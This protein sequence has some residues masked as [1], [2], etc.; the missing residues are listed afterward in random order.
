MYR[1]GKQNLLGIVAVLVTVTLSVSGLSILA[2][3][4]DERTPGA[5]AEAAPFQAPPAGAIRQEGTLI[6]PQSSIERLEDAGKFAHT[7][8]SIFV[9]AGRNM[10]TINP[11]NTFAEYPA[12]LAC[13]YKVGPA[14]PGC[15]PANNGKVATGGWGAIALVDAYDYPT[16]ASDLAFFSSYFGLPA[17][18]FF[19]VIA[20]SS[21]GAQGSLG[22]TASCSGTP[23]NANA[24]GWDVEEALDIEWAHAMAPAATIILVE[25]C[26]NSY[27]DLFVA[28]EVASN[29]VN[30]YGGGE[31]SNSWG[32]GE[33]SGE[34]NY[35]NYFY[36]D[37]WKH[38]TRFASAG[39]SGWGAAYP[40][41]SPWV[42]SAGG[43]TVNRNATTHNFMSESCWGGSGGGVSSQETWNN[44][45]FNGMGPWS[46]YQFPFAG[47]S[48]RQTPDMSFDADPA[49]GVYV[50]DTDSGH[51]WYIVGGT[52]V[53]SP[54]LAGIVNAAGNKL[55][56]APAG[57]GYYSATENNLIYAQLFTS[58][59]YAKNFYDVKTGSNGSGHNAG[60]GY[61]Q[62]TGVGSPRGKIG[63]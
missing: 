34:N 25:A 42:V 23:A 35:D 50:Y 8:Y 46:D 49:S 21:W 11:N 54:A 38:I 22:L 26:S 1:F 60:V 63:K 51:S 59:E 19:T 57:G 36:R 17:A 31:V 61:D 62:C 52:S 28:E 33:F 2:S 15:V 45:I 20:N 56:Q 43:T 40:S 4:Q 16:A 58:T 39:D 14:Y 48:A 13:V 47:Q 18:N 41:S 12:S 53:S 30:A 32:S 44:N 9:P 37:Y 6:K 24:T 55:G 7:N 27:N 10:A 29:Y 5:R 3:A